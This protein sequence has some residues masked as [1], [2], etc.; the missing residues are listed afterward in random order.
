MR[1]VFFVFK[2]HFSALFLPSVLNI[3]KFW[4]VSTLCV[5]KCFSCLND[6]RNTSASMQIK[7]KKSEREQSFS[8]PTWMS[9]FL[10]WEIGILLRLKLL[11]LRRKWKVRDKR[12]KVHDICLLIP[13][14]FF[15][16][17]AAI[18]NF[19]SEL[20]TTYFAPLL[21]FVASAT[22][23][24]ASGKPVDKEE[25]VREKKNVLERIFWSESF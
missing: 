14:L 6:C 17:A 7:R 5:R 18:N 1:F 22:A 23:A 20:V 10:C 16:F 19:V 11:Y 8:W 15:R 24:S 4:L 13:F 21:N 3:L 12:R 25:A 2:S 9:F